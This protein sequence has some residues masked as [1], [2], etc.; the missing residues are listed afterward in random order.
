MEKSLTTE[1]C[2]GHSPIRICNDSGKLATEFC[3]NVTESVGYLPERERNAVWSSQH[4]VSAVEV[5]E[6]TCDIHVAPPHQ[7]SFTEQVSETAS[8]CTKE[9]ERVMRCSCGE[10]QT[11]KLEKAPH[12]WTAWKVTKPATEKEE[13]LQERHCDIC[14]TKET[15]TIE[16]LKPTTQPNPSTNTTP[17]TG[18]SGGTNT[19]KEDNTVDSTTDPEVP[20]DGN[21]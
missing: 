2:E 1:S 7:H 10:T 13:G 14:Q 19:S 4:T 17:S 16:K 12:K 6:E 21:E 11:E 20:D 15:K 5:P 18:G 9:G 3:T 8:T